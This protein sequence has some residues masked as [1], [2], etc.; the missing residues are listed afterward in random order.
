MDTKSNAC[1]DALLVEQPLP[2]LLPFFPRDVC[3]PGPPLK[4]Q[5]TARRATQCD[6]YST[7]PDEAENLRERKTCLWIAQGRRVDGCEQTGVAVGFERDTV[8]RRCEIRS[9]TD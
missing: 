3:C 7:E 8:R 9:R 1:V 5:V 4:Q 2:L 6:Q